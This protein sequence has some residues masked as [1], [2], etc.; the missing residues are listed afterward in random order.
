MQP[1]LKD[2]HMPTRTDPSP[3]DDILIF[4][5]NYSDDN[6]RKLANDLMVRKRDLSK[7][8]RLGLMAI[9]FEHAIDGVTLEVW[10]FEEWKTWVKDRIESGLDLQF[11]RLDPKY[12]Q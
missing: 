1:S 11:V 9:L 8:D 12:N 3:L 10:N 4:L 5:N 7:V 2:L 6:L